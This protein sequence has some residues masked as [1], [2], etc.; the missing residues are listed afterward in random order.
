[1]LKKISSFL[2]AKAANNKRVH[3]FMI[4]AAA[5]F[6]L[7]FIFGIYYFFILSRYV[8]TDNAYIAAE[9]AQVTPSTGGI[10]K[11]IN[12]KDTDIV[13]TGDV[14]VIIDDTDAKLAFDY[15][16]AELDKAQVDFERTKIDNDRRAALAKSGS[17]SAEEVSNSKNAYKAAEAM[18]NAAKVTMQQA[19]VDLDRTTV[20]A[21]IGG[22]VVKRQVQLGQRVQAGMLLM[23][24]VPID[25]LYVNVNLKE[26]QLRKVKV[27]QSVELTSDLY[28]SSVVYHG[29]VV[30]FS[31]GT[32]AAFAVIPAQN[33]TGNWIKVVQRLPVRI[34][35]NP[36]ELRENP[37]KVGLSM[38]AEIDLDSCEK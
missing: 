14:L 16:K 8:Y 34:E 19:Q 11:S 33:A 15:A 27:G 38:Q 28:G 29:K 24:I 20:H 13:K 23:S 35:L 30:G 32:G 2:K 31:G 26:T 7:T 22:I 5:I 36:N 3:L 9:I 10:I 21:P 17:V 6:L 18:L 25:N 1:M 12:Y 4:L 37:L